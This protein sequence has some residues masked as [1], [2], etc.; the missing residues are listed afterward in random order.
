MKTM[1]LT[2]ALTLLLFLTLA[3]HGWAKPAPKHSHRYLVARQVAHGLRG[4]PLQ[5]LGFVFEAEAHRRNLSPFFLVGASG[6]ESSLGAAGCSG[7]RFNIWGLGA[8]NRYWHVPFF[9][10]WRHAISYYADFIRQH[11]PHARTVYDLH[12]YCECGSLSWGSQTL[13]WMH[14]LFQDVSGSV[15]YPR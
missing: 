4:T 11:W 1:T 9:P 3:D 12:G 13:A 15:L 6:T 8:C 10:T 5:G 14:R 7:N 2:V